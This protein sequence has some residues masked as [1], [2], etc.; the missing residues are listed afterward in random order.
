ML[1]ATKLNRQL[2]LELAV[3]AAIKIAAIVIG[4]SMAGLI[5]KEDPE[6]FGVV[7]QGTVVV[8]AGLMAFAMC[9]FEKMR[10]NT[11]GN[12]F[13]HFAVL[14]YLAHKSGSLTG[15]IS[16]KVAEDWCSMVR[17][18]REAIAVKLNKYTAVS[19]VGWTVVLLIASAI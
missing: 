16:D 6:Y 18:E 15:E 7:V 3:F 19:F 10:L 14:Y 2:K 1:I 9:Y 8:V 17:S 13:K 11:C 5:Y 12:K 4:G